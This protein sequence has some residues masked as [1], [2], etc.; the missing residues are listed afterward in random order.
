MNKKGKIK[1]RQ[2]SWRTKL[3]SL[4]VTAVM[5]LTLFPVTTL[6]TQAADAS[7]SSVEVT[8]IMGKGIDLDSGKYYF[9]NMFVAEK[10]T[11]VQVV[12]TDMTN[13]KSASLDIYYEDKLLTTTQSNDKGERQII[14]FV[15][16]KSAVNAWK[17]GRYKFTANINGES[18][19]TEAIFN[20]SRQ[21][22]VLVISASVK[23]EGQVYPAPDIDA[24]T[25]PLRTQALPVSESKL[26]AKYRNAKVSF[27]T[28]TGA[29][30]YDI[31][32]PEGQ[33]SFLSDIEK[34]RL[35]SASKYDVIVAVVNSPLGGA[36]GYTNETH[37]IVI[38]LLNKPNKDELGTTL[39]HET[40]HILGNGDEYIGGDFSVNI[41][42][43]PYGITGTENGVTVTGN[44]SY[45]TRAENNNY[46]CILIHD[47]Q[48]PYNPKSQ[49]SMLGH[50]SFM[51]SSYQHWTTS[52]VWEEAYR[53][54]VPNSQNILPRVYTDGSIVPQRPNSNDL[55]EAELNELKRKYRI[56]LNEVRAAAGYK[57]Y[58]EDKIMIAGDK[59]MQEVAEETLQKRIFRKQIDLEPMLTSISADTK[60][61][62]RVAGSSASLREYGKDEIENMRD[63]Y[64]YCPCGQAQIARDYMFLA[65][66]RADNIIY[67]ME[68]EVSGVY[69][70]PPNEE[71]YKPQPE[72]PPVPEINPVTNDKINLADYASGQYEQPQI[73]DLINRDTPDT[74]EP[75]PQAYP[76]YSELS[77]SE[78]REILYYDAHQIYLDKT[79]NYPFDYVM[80][81]YSWYVKEFYDV[82]IS[83]SDADNAIQK[84]LTN[85]MNEYNVDYY[86]PFG[87][88]ELICR[89]YGLYPPQEM[90]EGDAFG[91]AMYKN[92]FEQGTFGENPKR[93]KLDTDGEKY[94]YKIT[95]TDE[96][97]EAIVI[98][99]D[100]DDL[101][102]SGDGD[103]NDPDGNW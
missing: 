53:H 27:G 26:A 29:N 45:F 89:H 24:N 18:K 90:R 85:F 86:L 97:G 35:K 22:S 16:D 40:G 98:E 79:I 103:I 15:P 68:N 76:A 80:G 47:V 42:G 99:S 49:T 33:M 75:A 83:A 39:L 41:N 7:I 65:F 19:T 64:T 81:F 95:G 62:F 3:L 28:G 59:R 96:T 4:V 58:S 82:N 6:R 30:G 66:V 21:F 77:Q 32:T 91:E 94:Y 5:V 43:A 11:A 71:E 92:G 56:M 60:Y 13:I 67:F 52:M 55:T 36:G 37:A 72:E 100:P 51:G 23:F 25:I 84:F 10:P 46:S 14:T 63:F 48:N 31:S 12:M 74:A 73:P 78:R 9:M 34:Y 50:S 61:M 38:T 44:R 102:L 88:F 70:R 17:A 69:P 20:D 54:L 8:Q 57:P 2:I 93:S 87:V 1:M 101:D